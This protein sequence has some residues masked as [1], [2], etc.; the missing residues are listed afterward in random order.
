MKQKDGDMNNVK[1]DNYQIQAT[2]HAE[3]PSL[4]KR[5]ASDGRV[6]EPQP[7]WNVFSWLWYSWATP[8]LGKCHKMDQAQRKQRRQAAGGRKDDLKNQGRHVPADSL[9]TIDD[10]YWCPEAGR[11]AQATKRFMDLWDRHGKSQYPW[12]RMIFSIL[13][14]DL[15]KACVCDLILVTLEMLVPLVMGYLLQLL[16]IHHGIARAST[17]TSKFLYW[18]NESG[19]AAVGWSLGLFAMLVVKMLAANFSFFSMITA[20]IRLQTAITGALY[21][22]ALRFSYASSQKYVGGLGVNVAGADPGR[23]QLFAKSCNYFFTV[24]IQIALV[25]GVLWWR[26]GAAC[27]PGLAVLAG[28]VPVQLC[29]LRYQKMCR[30]V[31]GGWSIIVHVCR[32]QTSFQMSA[33]N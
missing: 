12:A 19:W 8:F 14:V 20:S 30:K 24:P 31:R 3:D 4:P 13:G 32:K 1:P 21:E 27:L 10:V 9:V 26:I 7:R 33:S 11:A 2:M 18:S 22:K 6:N 16:A 17:A 28:Y 15:L 29:M 25:V 5:M 23:I